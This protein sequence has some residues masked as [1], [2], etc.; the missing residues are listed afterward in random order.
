M[1]LN[2]RSNCETMRDYSRPDALSTGAQFSRR[3]SLLNT[4]N[5]WWPRGTDRWNGVCKCPSRLNRVTKPEQSASLE[6]DVRAEVLAEPALGA[7]QI[8]VGAS[9]GAVTLAGAVESYFEKALAEAV[10]LRVAGVRTV[11]N[12]LTVEPPVAQRRSDTSIAEAAAHALNWNVAVPAA[13]KAVVKDGW[14]TLHGAV[15]WRYERMAAERSVRDL[16]G[17]LGLT[18]LITVEK[19]PVA[20]DIKATLEHRLQRSALVDPRRIAI[21]VDEVHVRLLG[22]ARSWAD[23]EEAERLAWTVPG[24][25]EVDNQIA[26][27]R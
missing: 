19:Q 15:T 16:T 14:I 17:V 18:N 23:R 4:S 5:A 7:R 10:A 26:I 27:S 11:A 13:V 24:V 9:D 12:D 6:S 21:E 1:N 2:L 22:A 8:R 25:I 20:I 3:A